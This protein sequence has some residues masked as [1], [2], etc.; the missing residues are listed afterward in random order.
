LDGAAPPAAS[1]NRFAVSSGRA[2]IATCTLHRRHI[3]LQRYQGE[4]DCSH[5]KAAVEQE[6]YYFRSR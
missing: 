4:L 2:S 5:A 6:R 3:V 1:K